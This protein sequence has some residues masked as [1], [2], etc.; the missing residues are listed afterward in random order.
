MATA[1]EKT[2]TEAKK[3]PQPDPKTY[4]GK[5]IM[6]IRDAISGD[7]KFNGTDGEQAV[8]KLEDGEELTVLRSELED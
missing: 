7:P 8:I 1:K 3:P 2:V 5:K 4:Q 6:T